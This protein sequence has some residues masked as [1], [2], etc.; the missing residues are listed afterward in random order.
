MQR[1]L[2]SV[3]NELDGALAWLGAM[4][5]RPNTRFNEYRKTFVTV[6]EHLIAGKL[7]ELPGLVTLAH[8]RTAFIESS[9]LIEIAKTLDR[10]RGPRFSEKVRKAVSGP[11]HPQDE[12]K[13]GSKARDFLFELSV[14]AY[15]RRRGLPVTLWSER[16][17]ITRVPNCTILIEC[18]RPQSEK[19]VARSIQDATKQLIEHFENYPRGFVRYGFIALDISVVM[20]P[21]RMF[22][23][24]DSYDA[25]NQEADSLF[26]RLL[27]DFGLALS[28]R[29]D[30]RVLG[31]LAFAKVLA[32]CEP[33]NCSL[34]L[35]KIQP[36]I[37]APRGSHEAT[38][39]EELCNYFSPGSFQDSF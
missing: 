6:H 26:H 1:D 32:Y 28:Y 31:V 10:L 4:G 22:V 33:Q 11:V 27:K 23:L 29:R 38:L 30:K 3:I 5:I 18:K 7:A 8:Y 15:F 25:I 14:A 21:E 9:Y 34:S 35:H 39:A 17:L 2:T 12:K 19:K 16:D 13:S 36:Y 37:H 24:G 20:N